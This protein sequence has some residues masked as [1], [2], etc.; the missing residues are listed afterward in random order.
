MAATRGL[1]DAQR[2]AIAELERRVVANDGGRL[3]LEWEILRQRPRTEVNDLLA[4]DGSVLVGFC[5]LYSFGAEPEIAGAV[6]PSCRR[7]GVASVLLDR[8]LE[9]LGGR[10]AVAALLV[11]PA[12]SGAGRAFAG[13]RGATFHHAEHHLELPGSPIGPPPVR[14]ETAGLCVRPATPDDRGAVVEILADA[15]GDGAAPFAEGAANDLALVVERHAEV[16]GALRLSVSRGAA[17]IY[18]F[19]VR[20]GL[21]GRGIGRAAL[22]AACLEARRRGAT[23]VTLEVAVENDHALGLYTSVGFERRTT[24]EY[25]EI[26]VPP[27]SVNERGPHLVGG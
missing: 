1:T 13:A 19:A 11:T 7:R 27:R 26:A 16:V 2:E 10:G 17:G 3:K 24:E 23:T 4:W 9:I 15:F 21:R 12:A 25:F 20:S 5:G 18:G 22:Y 14:A 8:A 6:D